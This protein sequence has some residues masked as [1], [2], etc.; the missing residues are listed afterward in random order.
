ML[1][2]KRTKYRKQQRGKNRGVATRGNKV[3]FGEFGLIRSTVAMFSDYA[4]F[5]LG[6][7]LVKYV[8]EW[9]ETDKPRAG[10]IIAFCYGVS[11]L[12]AGIFS[13]VL[14]LCSPYICNGIIDSPHIIYS[15]RLGILLFIALVYNGIQYGLLGGFHYFHAI[16]IAKLVSGLL[17][18]PAV[19]FGAKF[20]GMDGAILG[21]S[22]A[23]GSA[24]L[25]SAYFVR[26]AMQEHVLMMDFRHCLREVPILWKSALPTALNVLAFAP[27]VWV[28]YLLVARQS[29]G[30]SMLA[31]VVA[32]VQLNFIMTFVT[33]QT[34]RVFLASASA[35]YAKS[36]YK[37]MRKIIGVNLLVN[38][39]ST[40]I[41]AL[42]FFL[43]A[44]IF[45]DFV[46]RFLYSGSLDPTDF[47]PDCPY[48]GNL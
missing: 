46:W 12:T 27:T 28:C 35:A 45:Y 25:I 26:K 9:I 48:S 32:A 23:T 41:I 10:R 24:I 22:L 34:W 2:P 38:I 5:G 42:P 3:S 19:I 47:L 14:F 8:S 6:L 15:L 39:V 29:G 20:Y 44:G 1:Q 30:T 18:I 7:L 21:F 40:S 31:L 16:F 13:V 37:A 11:C 43:D 4:G 33:S 17:M 36:N